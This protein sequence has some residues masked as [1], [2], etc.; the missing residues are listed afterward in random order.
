[1]TEAAEV[2]AAA[3]PFF[4]VATWAT[5]AAVFGLLL[6]SA[7]FSGSET[8]LTAASRA[9]LRRLADDG[10]AGAKTALALSDDNE[11]L[12]GSILLGNNLVNIL[13]TSLATSLLLS[14]FGESGVA[15]ATLAMTVLVLVF[16]EVLPKTY[17]ITRPETAATT[18][19]PT[20]AL[21]VRL[22]APV[23]SLVRMIVRGALSLAGVMTDPDAQILAREEIKG[24]IDLHHYEG[25][26]AREARDRLLGALELDD[27]EVAQV[28]IHRRNIFTI[29]A[30]SPPE[31]ILS[32]CLR[33]PYTRIPLYRENS[34][35]IVGV[36]H[37]KAPS[38][39]ASRRARRSGPGRLGGR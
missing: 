38:P 8:A 13:A 36:V 17:A 21:A 39:R 29:N 37:A 18:V 7:F 16:A 1:M 28:M 31:Q 3:D 33:S 2:A 27:R 11:R 9:R 20:V 25:A 5:A 4:S 30:E 26:V 10:S 19:A 15:I 34:E 12:I 23:V 14:L 6:L 22:F 24:A 32:E 35:N